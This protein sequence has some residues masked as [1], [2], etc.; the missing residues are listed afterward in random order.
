MK[1]QLSREARVRLS[2][3]PVI[4]RAR[5]WRLYGSNG[6]RYLDLWAEGGRSIAGRRTGASGRIAKESIDRGLDA[7]FP[8]FWEGRLKKA[9]LA[10]LP[11][12]SSLKFFASE[13]EALLALAAADGNF[14]AGTGGGTGFQAALNGFAARL[15]VES[16]FGAYRRDFAADASHTAFG[17]SLAIAVLPLADAWCFGVVIGKEPTA[18]DKAEMFRSMELDTPV[19]AIKLATAARALADFRAFEAASDERKW[20]AIDPHIAGTFTR[21][22]PWL[23]PVYPESDHDRVFSKCL[24]KGILISPDYDEPSSVPGEFDSGE[25]AALRSVWNP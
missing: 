21:S 9:I 25:V 14:V 22:G 13:T 17:G 23:Y 20:S 3:L 2:A 18:I 5:G 19:P 12:Y 8:S 15:R 16:P 24:E 1:L 6:K 4:A 10:W 7:S 11:A